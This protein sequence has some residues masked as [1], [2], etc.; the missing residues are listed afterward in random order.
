MNMYISGASKIIYYNHAGNIKAVGA[1]AV[2]E[3]IYEIAE[4][5]TR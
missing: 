5:S 4:E 3:C 1:E 2:E